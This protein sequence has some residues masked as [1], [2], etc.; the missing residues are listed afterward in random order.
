MATLYVE[1]TIGVTKRGMDA[2][3]DDRT[4][5]LFVFAA[6]GGSLPT[7]RRH[8]CAEDIARGNG[9]ARASSTNW[10]ARMS[11]TSKEASFVL[12]LGGSAA[13]SSGFGNFPAHAP[14]S[15]CQGERAIL[16][17][18]QQAFAHTSFELLA[19]ILR[20]RHDVSAPRACTFRER[21]PVV[22]E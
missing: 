16:A 22:I 11:F 7:R 8:C 13:L 18:H 19:T 17:I 3:H 20:K 9:N 2:L 1:P 12:P 21:L 15:R 6:D 14:S 10:T 5:F 4:L